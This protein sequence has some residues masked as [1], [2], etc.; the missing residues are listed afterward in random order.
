MIVYEHDIEIDAEDALR[1]SPVARSSLRV[2]RHA[3]AAPRRVGKVH[4]RQGAYVAVEP[5]RIVGAA[6]QFVL[7]V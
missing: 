1:R 6:D 4:D 2:L 5:S 3:P 7:D